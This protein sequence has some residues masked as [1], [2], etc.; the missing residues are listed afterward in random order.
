M[1]MGIAGV[2]AMLNSPLPEQLDAMNST[3]VLI[4]VIDGE[5][6]VPV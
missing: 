6:H 3:G 2:T 4:V 1:G 5:N